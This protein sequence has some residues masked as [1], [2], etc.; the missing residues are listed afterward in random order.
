MKVVDDPTD[1]MDKTMDE[2][3]ITKTRYLHYRPQP[4]PHFIHNHFSLITITINDI[5]LNKIKTKHPINLVM[6]SA[7]F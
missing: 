1:R 6:T 2:M 3:W 4:Y 5:I 7:L